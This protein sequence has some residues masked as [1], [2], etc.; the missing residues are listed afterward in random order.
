[1]PQQHPLTFFQPVASQPR[2]PISHI[3]TKMSSIYFNNTFGG[4]STLDRVPVNIYWCFFF[5]LMVLRK[6]FVYFGK[7]C[8]AL[9]FW[10]IDSFL[11]SKLVEIRNG[12]ICRLY[13]GFSGRSSMLL[14]NTE[15]DIGTLELSAHGRH[16]RFS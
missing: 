7:S 10:H 11:W 4:F 14:A 6:A 13:Y 8:L 12:G 9:N 3:A 2:S 1:M 5:V 16:I 15:A